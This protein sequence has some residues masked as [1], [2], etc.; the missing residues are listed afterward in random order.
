MIHSWKEQ[1][2]NRESQKEGDGYL[3]TSLNIK[4]AQASEADSVSSDFSH[5]QTQ[6]GRET[7]KGDGGMLR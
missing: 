3:K 7:Q 1:L 5:R 4:Q 6:T 2:H